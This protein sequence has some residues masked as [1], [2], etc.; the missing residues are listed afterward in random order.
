M[1]RPRLFLASSSGGHIDLLLRLRPIFADF[2][3][4][5]VTQ[6]SDRSAELTRSGE[7]VIVLPEYS[8]NPVA[9][10][11]HVS[12]WRS[13]RTVMRDR[14]SNVVTTGSGLVVPFCTMARAAGARLLFIETAAR[15]C[16]ASRSGLVLSRLAHHTFV[17][18]SSMRAV[19]R[20]AELGRPSIL[21][22]V[23]PAERPPA[24]T[25]TFV[26]V[27][28][29]TYPFDRLLHIVDEAA[30]S[31]LLPRPVFAQTGV[32]QYVPRHFESQPWLTPEEVD[33]RIAAAR[34][35]VTHGGTGLMSTALSHGRRPLV[36]TRQGALREHFD[37]HQFQLVGELARMS[38][39][40]PIADHITSD[41][42]ANADRALVSPSGLEEVPRLEELLVDVLRSPQPGTATRFSTP[43]S[44]GRGSA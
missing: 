13:L 9:S 37:D 18:W 23:C 30:G 26:G 29:M 42:L 40:V 12:L 3:R 20:G 15:V 11:V 39:V 31:G 19:Y 6:P 5:W 14:P 16:S 35:V 21:D 27:G 34:L 36:L 41:D 22:R 43:G 10:R 2:E 24:G 4:I 7:R 33:A 25:G 1:T 38:L 17:Q 28:T 44:G 8:R 32:S